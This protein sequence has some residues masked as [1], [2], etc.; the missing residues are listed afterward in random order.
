M[1]ENLLYK[2]EDL[3][4]IYVSSNSRIEHAVVLQSSC[5]DA[6]MT[7]IHHGG[8]EQFYDCCKIESPVKVYIASAYT[9]FTEEERKQHTGR[10]FFG[11]RVSGV[12]T[13]LKPTEKEYLIDV[14]QQSHE[15]NY[16]ELKLLVK[17]VEVAKKFNFF[18]QLWVIVMF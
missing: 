16:I 10:V 6:Q 11:G 8:G 2:N 13:I 5:E 17:D 18:R 3:K 14:K 12:E 7:M 9:C 1:D 4:L 15:S